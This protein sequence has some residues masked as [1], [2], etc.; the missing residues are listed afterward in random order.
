MKKHNVQG[1]KQSKK[2]PV[3]VMDKFFKG[4]ILPKNIESLSGW[5]S[6]YFKIHVIGSPKKTEMAKKK[7]LSKFL[8]YF[9]REVGHDR[10]DG[11]TPAV[12]KQFQ[13]ELKNKISTFTNK[14]YKATTI[15]R[16]M[17][18]VKHFGGWLNKQR[19]LLAGSPFHAV[20]DIQ[21]D[22]PDWNGLTNRQ[23]MRLKAAC[24]QRLKSCNR[25]DQNPLL[26]T[27]VF[28][29]LLH[30][31]LRESE[32]TSLNINQYHH[33]GFHDVKRKGNRITKKVSVPAEAKEM[34][35]RYLRERKIKND[36]PLFIS[37]Y[38]KRIAAQDV[39]RICLRLSNQASA[40]L[41]KSEAFR[42]TP[43]MLRHTF[44]KRVADKHG[45]HVAQQMSGNVSI[46]EIFRYTKPSQHEIDETAEE[47]FK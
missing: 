46:Q 33:R 18:T 40:H 12:T 21:T 1:F 25:A 5:A 20:K 10:V 30:T 29:V 7:D 42:L 44:L 41:N 45:V 23:I 6:L 39:A 3:I 34:L 9:A 24:E 8:D 37:R 17:A 38:K 4:K 16:V 32:L 2:T 31:G 36:D 19:P 13:H 15:N 27:T 47:L 22:E 11:W 28:F 35:D 14:P 26:E 43:H